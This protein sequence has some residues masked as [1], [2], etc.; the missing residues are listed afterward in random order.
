MRP[1]DVPPERVGIEALVGREREITAVRALLAESVKRSAAKCA[2]ITG[3]AGIGKSRLAAEIGRVAGSLGL[4]VWW[5]RGDPN[6][7]PAPFGT[8]S[9]V[10]HRL[11]EIGPAEP[12]AERRKKLRE[13][14]GRHVDP[15]A[16]WETAAVLGEA[17][18][19]SF[20][21]GDTSDGAPAAGSVLLADLAMRAWEE[22]LAAELAAGPV[23]LVL[24]DAH[25][26]DLPSMR[27]FDAALRNLSNRPFAVVALGRDTLVTTFPVLFVG[28]PDAS[29][30]LEELTEAHARALLVALASDRVAPAAL[31]A[32]A[33]A[34]GGNPFV[35]EE[36]ARKLTPLPHVLAEAARKL[37]PV[38]PSPV[39]SSIA[40]GGGSFAA[41]DHAGGGTFVAARSPGATGAPPSDVPRT[42]HGVAAARI[43]AASPATQWVLR[44]ASVLGEVFA[45]GDLAALLEGAIDAAAL[46]PAIEEACARELLERRPGTATAGTDETGT[47]GDLAFRTAL[48]REVAYGMLTEEDRAHA[49]RLAAHRLA[50]EDRDP[51]VLAWHFEHGGAPAQAVERYKVAALRALAANDFE[52]AIARGRRA[53]ACGAQGK[54]LGEVARILADAYLWRGETEAAPREARRAVELLEPDTVTWFQASTAFAVAASRLGDT[55]ALHAAARD[56]ESLLA[57]RPSS[58]VEPA[59]RVAQVTSMSRLAIALAHAG[60]V[61]A[62]EPMLGRMHTLRM[63]GAL[64]A[65]PYALGQ[66]HRAHAIRAHARD[67]LMAAFLAFDAAAASFE[68]AGAL[69]DACVDHANSGF[70]KTELGQNEDAEKLQSAALAAAKRLSLPTV[71]ANAQLNLCLLLTRRGAALPAAAMGETALATFEKQ[72]SARMITIANVYLARALLVG[73]APGPA[74]QRAKRAT[75]FGDDVLPYKAYAFGALSAA[76]LALGHPAEAME[77]AETAMATL[78]EYGAEEGA[79]FVRLAYVEALDAVDRVTEA[80]DALYEADAALAARASKIA[81]PSHREAF[82]RNIPEHART[83]ERADTYGVGQTS[84][85]PTM[86][87][88]S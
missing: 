73:G 56:L 52:T 8:L 35:L 55:G 67:E 85:A 62:A 86:I 18:G 48:V 74:R 43:E 37:T 3:P 1:D 20:V 42:A 6:G 5:G 57:A 27:L 66:A 23:V 87:A 51:A 2:V 80:R 69:R 32:A 77:A 78:R 7:R 60:D 82:L 88:R 84:Q 47:D 39:A 58:S 25:S 41:P 70:M 21:G 79:A 19:T 83:M 33:A 68:R 75:D 26:A 59:L 36:V 44:A 28:H 64:D 30:E 9:D 16:L 53:E 12:L 76:E 29:L 40:T 31:D 63:A 17:M 13:R 71:V 49:H 24:D 65:L 38:T 54:T 46:D 22:L 11:A 10:L 81:D 14:V 50:A 61:P 15:D 4:T 34:A 72:G 45:R